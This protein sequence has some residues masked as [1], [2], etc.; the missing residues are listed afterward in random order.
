MTRALIG[1]G[2]AFVLWV[3][4]AL[5]LA[6]SAHGAPQPNY[7]KSHVP[8]VDRTHCVLV[9]QPPVPVGA[10]PGSTYLSVNPTTGEDRPIP[11]RYRGDVRHVRVDFLSE[12]EVNRVCAGGVADCSAIY[13]A[14]DEGKHITV[15]NPCLYLNESFAETLCHEL[16][17]VNGWAAWH[18]N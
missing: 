14:C 17:H 8:Q 12:D 6:P 11:M 16:A 3:V 2:I 18:P 4:I 10:S 15:P 5:G 13:Y 7:V 1:L 9:K